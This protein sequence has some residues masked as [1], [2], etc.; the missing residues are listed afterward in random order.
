MLFV[1]LVPLVPK[2]KVQI[3]DVAFII[4]GTVYVTE[5]HPWQTVAIPDIVPAL[6]GKGFIFIEKV[7]VPPSPQSL[8]PFTVKIP[9]VA[10]VEK[11]MIAAAP[12]LLMVAPLPV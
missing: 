7:E 12:A 6:A 1:V 3:V 9:L 8:C 11:S 10:V 4:V 5:F 2:G